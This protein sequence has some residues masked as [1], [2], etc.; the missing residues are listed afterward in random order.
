MALKKTQMTNYGVSGEYWRVAQTNIN[1]DTMMTHIEVLQ[2]VNQDIRRAENKPIGAMSFDI[3]ILPYMALNIGPVMNVAAVVYGILKT[4]PE[5]AEAEDVID[6]GQVAVKL[7][8][9]ENIEVPGWVE[10]VV[11]EEPIIEDPQERPDITP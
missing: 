3:S 8:E 7:N 9:L 4:L 10:P 11:E 1:W 2:Y 6:A 5:F